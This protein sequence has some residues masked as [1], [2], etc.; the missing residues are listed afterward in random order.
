MCIRDSASSCCSPIAIAAWPERGVNGASSA[1]AA[2]RHPPPPPPPSTGVCSQRSPCTCPV[3]S[4]PPSNHNRPPTAVSVQPPRL[5]GAS[6]PPLPLGAASAHATDT[7]G[8]G[9]G[10]L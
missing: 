9:G 8:G 10:G 1:S 4:A 2:R 6:P 3:R 5:A 7:R